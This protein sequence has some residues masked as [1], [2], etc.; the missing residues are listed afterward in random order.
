MTAVMMAALR[1]P[2]RLLQLLLPVT[3]VLLVLLWVL[4]MLPRVLLLPVTWVLQVLLA[5]LLLKRLHLWGLQLPV[6]QQGARV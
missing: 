2:P 4:H 5:K 1:L 6:P 3:C